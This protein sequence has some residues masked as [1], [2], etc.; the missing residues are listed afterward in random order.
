VAVDNIIE[1]LPRKREVP[2]IRL[3]HPCRVMPSVLDYSL[4]VQL[5]TCDQG[6]IVAEIREE[7]DG[8]NN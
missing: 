6:Q 4:D 8:I 1:R 3:G 2:T 7:I 5:K